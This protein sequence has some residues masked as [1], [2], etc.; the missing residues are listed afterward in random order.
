M[1]RSVALAETHERALPAG[2]PGTAT[3]ITHGAMPTAAAA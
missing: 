2:M 1:S 3:L